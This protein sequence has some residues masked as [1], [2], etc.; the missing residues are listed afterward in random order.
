M[1]INYVDFGTENCLKYIDDLSIMLK[2]LVE[3]YQVALQCSSD[4]KQILS[5]SMVH[6]GCK[7]TRIKQNWWGSTL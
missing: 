5:A 7:S 1:A 3:K 4:L 2:Y 6:M